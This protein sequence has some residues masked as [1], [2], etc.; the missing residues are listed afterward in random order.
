MTERKED[1]VKERKVEEKKTNV[2]T[3]EKDHPREHYEQ[4]NKVAKPISLEELFK[5]RSSKPDEPKSE[6]RKVLLYG[7]PGS[8]KTCI[9]KAI[10]HKWALGEIMPEFEAIYVIPIR[11][12]NVIRSKSPHGVTLKDMVAQIC[13]R[14]RSDDEYEDLLTQLEGD[15]DLPTTLLMFDGLDEAS[16]DA[17]ELVHA[18]EER[19]CK[20]LILTK[21]YNLQQIRARVDCEF[22]C[23]GFNDQELKN[24][25]NKELQQDEASR[26]IRS[27]Q[28]NQGLWENAHTPVTA[29][30]LCSLS[31]AHGT[32]SEDKGKRA[33]MFQIYNDM[34]NFVW[35]RFE[36][37]PEARMS[38]K[39][40]VF[41]D[42]EKIAFEALRSGQ[43]LIEQRIVEKCATST[44]ASK[45]FKESGFLLLVLE[46]QEYQ[47]PHLTFQEY[48][49]GK[50]IAGSLKKKGSDEE[51]QAL[52][53]IQRGKYNEKRDLTISF[54]MHAFAEGRSKFAL[55][56]MLSIVDE[57]PIEVLGVQHFFLR[58]RVLDATLEEANK[59]DLKELLEDDQAIKLVES[60]RQL[61][62]RTIDDV[63][64]QE[65]VIEKLRQLSCILEKFPQ[66]LDTAID[67]VK[68]LLA[69]S[70]ELT[71]MEMDR[72]IDVLKL[73]RNSSKQ[74]HV[75][76]Q[77]V[78]QLAEQ[79]LGWCDSMECIKRLSCIG[80]QI[81]QHAAEVLPLLAEWCVDVSYYMRES[82]MEAIGSVVVAAMQHAGEVLPTLAKGGVD[83]ES[84]VR[85]RAMEA[86]GRV[87]VAAPQHAGEV[88]PLLAK[89]CDDE[90][91]Y[92][93]MGEM[94][95]FGRVVVAA[96]Q[97][98]GEVLPTLAKGGVDEESVVRGRAMEAFGRVVVAAPQH[99]GEVLPLL[100][101]G[102]FDGS[103]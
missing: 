103:D 70:R 3:Q 6:I 2:P 66:V 45:F 14:E 9:G 55:Q 19:L 51:K 97:H 59:N 12:V 8:G 28:K 58:L 37:K 38:N 43:I 33:S 69:N 21:P 91:P 17:R 75:L 95:A 25:I 52:E 11:R 71:W 100:A 98:A 78:L 72:I 93:R 81:P 46:G 102:R 63:I 1:R 48:F 64:I 73:A 57:K 36:E 89:G 26:L 13:F 32:F 39:M 87:V 92:A 60:A 62:E 47:F 50:H 34:T 54:A 79:P 31:K 76:I 49:G 80:K 53:F 41:G 96:P 4:K 35:K 61:L 44:N 77:F 94:E 5:P 40:A 74:S 29:H 30:I 88:L 85:G 101:K 42:L 20:L 67:R 24:Y 90:D 23:L 10:A 84:V 86:F 15:L 99:A 18:A 7:N 68:K 22:E 16:E 65:I 82:V 27:L 83:E 56:E